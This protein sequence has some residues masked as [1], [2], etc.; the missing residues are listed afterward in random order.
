MKADCI[1]CICLNCKKYKKCNSH[2]LYGC[3]GVIEM[4][5]DFKP[6]FNIGKYIKM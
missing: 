2:I 1:K 6:K 3:E 5:T 4:C